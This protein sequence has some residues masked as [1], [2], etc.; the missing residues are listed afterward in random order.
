M[1]QRWIAN[2]TRSAYFHMHMMITLPLFNHSFT[3]SVSPSGYDAEHRN[4]EVLT[5]FQCSRVG[6]QKTHAP[7]TSTCIWW[8]PCHYSTNYSFTQSVSPYGY[9]AEHR[10]QEV[11]TSFQCSRVGIQKTHAPRTSTCIW[12]SPCHYST[13]VLRRAFLLQVTTQSIVTRR[14][15]WQSTMF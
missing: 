13:T 9:D 2:Y 7:R 4:Q 10:N 6:M 12:W 1:L 3:Q 14:T 11:L 8:S 15:M 5:S